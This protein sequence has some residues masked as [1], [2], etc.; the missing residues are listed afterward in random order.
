MVNYGKGSIKSCNEMVTNMRK[1]WKM[2]SFYNRFILFFTV[3]CLHSWCFAL[4]P[5]NQYNDLV[6]G[7]GVPGYEDGT[8]YSAQFHKPE[9]LALNDDGSILYVA[10]CENNCIRA[11]DLNHQNEVKTIAGTGLAGNQNGSFST[12]TFNHPFCLAVLPDGQIAVGEEGGTKGTIIRLIDLNSK[13]VSTLVGSGTSVADGKG[14]EVKLNDIWNMAYRASDQSLYFSEPKAGALKRFD[15]KTGLIETVLQNHPLIPNPKALCVYNDKLYVADEDIR[16]L[17]DLI[18]SVEGMENIKKP[19]TD[20]KPETQII[21]SV[22]TGTKGPSNPI[23]LQPIGNAQAIV[24]L[25]GSATGLYAYEAS[26]D[27]KY[28]SPIV[29]LTALSHPLTFVSIWGDPIYLPHGLFPYFR[30]VDNSSAVGFVSDPRSEGRFYISDP[31]THLIA[32]FRDLDFESRCLGCRDMDFPAKKPFRTFR[33]LIVGRSYPCLIVNRKF[34][35]KDTQN[36]FESTLKTF[37]TQLE[38]ELNMEAALNDVPI[39]FEVMMYHAI[40]D[41]HIWNWG[42]NMVPVV[43]KLKDIDLALITLDPSQSSLD[44]FYLGPIASDGTYCPS[45]DPEFMLKPDSEKFMKAP[46]R[47][48]FELCKRKNLLSTAGNKKWILAPFSKLISDS[49]VRS[50]IIGL[51]GEPFVRSKKSW[52]CN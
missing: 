43:D 48:F 44:D 16:N 22:P 19:M 45:T 28:S 27:L 4:S 10:D 49:E 37:P 46:L 20:S 8:F 38:L 34:D 6:A 21:A 12:A 25:A 3:Y 7:E 42:P 2:R 15:L 39:H 51:M 18:Y 13:N 26:T 31:A 24:A 30:G 23:Q 32:S 29:C 35:E 47:S 5:L 33:I 9:G 41:V 14:T 52:I 1:L 17:H 36:S 11:V 50:R 40:Q